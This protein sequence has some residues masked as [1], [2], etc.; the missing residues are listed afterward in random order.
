MNRSS[1]Q[2]CTYNTGE[3]G[4]MSQENKNRAEFFYKALLCFHKRSV[5]RNI[6]FYFPGIRFFQSPSVLLILR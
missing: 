6:C 3:Q 1:L 5:Y 2:A 4:K